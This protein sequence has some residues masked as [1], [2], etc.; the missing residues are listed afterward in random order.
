MCS[1]VIS[2]DL[3]YGKVFLEIIKKWLISLFESC[4][5]YVFEIVLFLW[6]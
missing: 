3:G 5:F 2:C 6:I 4:G 1:G